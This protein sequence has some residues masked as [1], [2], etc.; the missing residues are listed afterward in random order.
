VGGSAGGSRGTLVVAHTAFTR[1]VSYDGRAEER[2]REDTMS[3]YYP[4]LYA[5]A[6]PDRSWRRQE[7]MVPVIPAE[8]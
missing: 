2:G 6:R 4:R 5:H 1:H 7:L 3:V 8:A